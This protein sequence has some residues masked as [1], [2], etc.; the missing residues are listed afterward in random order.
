MVDVDFTKHLETFCYFWKSCF[1]DLA[2]DRR[3][4][5][6]RARG[7]E[8]LEGRVADEGWDGKEQGGGEGRRWRGVKSDDRARMQKYK[9]CRDW[10]LL[11]KQVE[12]YGV[13]GCEGRRVGDTS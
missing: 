1:V 7:C 3:D 4:R 11:S 5:R 9:D 8:S 2:R 10:Y 13:S 6:A 12:E